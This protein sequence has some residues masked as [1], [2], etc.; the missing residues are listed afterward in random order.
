M[1][2]EDKHTA[3]VNAEDSDPFALQVFSQLL[4]KN[5]SCN[6]RLAVCSIRIIRFTLLLTAC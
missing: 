1:N 3:R 4:G 6:I 2:D 5:C